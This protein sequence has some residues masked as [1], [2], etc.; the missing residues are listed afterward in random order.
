M[1][2]LEIYERRCCKHGHDYQ[3]GVIDTIYCRACGNIIAVMYAKGLDI[4]TQ[5]INRHIND[6]K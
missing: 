4:D 6:K 2:D 5:E 3:V 1:M